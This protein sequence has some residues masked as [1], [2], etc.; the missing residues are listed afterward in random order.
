MKVANNKILPKRSRGVQLPCRASFRKQ[1]RWGEHV[2]IQRKATFFEQ[3]TTDST[4]ILARWFLTP[5]TKFT[6]RYVCKTL[7]LVFIEKENVEESH[8]RSHKT[9]KK[10]G[11][12]PKKRQ[13]IAN[14]FATFISCY[15]AQKSSWELLSWLRAVRS[16]LIVVGRL[17]MQKLRWAEI[18]AKL[19][20]N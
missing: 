1:S 19:P 11:R 2:H 6:H 4:I 10:I 9:S 17:A 8:W 14:V 12:F 16:L 3:W 7:E 13:K 18:T 5:K 20:P 15:Y